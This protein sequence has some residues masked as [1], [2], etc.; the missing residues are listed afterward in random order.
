MTIALLRGELSKLETAER[1]QASNAVRQELLLASTVLARE[2][3]KTFIHLTVSNQDEFGDDIDQMRADAEEAL[4]QA[5]A[6]LQSGNGLLA[7]AGESHAQVV[8]K[9]GRLTALRARID[10]AIGVGDEGARLAAAAAWLSEA[11]A[12]IDD[13]QATRLDLLNDNRPTDAVLAAEANIRAY[14]DI[15]HEAVAFNEAIGVSLLTYEDGEPGETLVMVERILGR[16]SLAWQMIENEVDISLSS[17]VRAAIANAR[18]HYRREY[19]PLLL[20]LVSAKA[21]AATASMVANWEATSDKMLDALSALQDTVIV[22]SSERLELLVRDARRSAIIFSLVAGAG[23]VAAVLILL[24]VRRRVIQPI[25]RISGAMVR[26]A[27]NDLSTPVPRA[28]RLDE[29][30]VMT[31]ALRTF[32]ANAIQR[33]RTQREL[34]S[35]HQN[36]QRTFDQ[37]RHDLEAAATIQLAMLPAPAIVDGISHNGLYSPSSLVAGDT[38]NVIAQP[39]G[40]VGFFQIDVA[41]HGAAAALVSVA[42]QHTLSQAILTR[43]R[44]EP[45]EKILAQVNREWPEDLPYFTTILGEIDA[46]APVGR[47]VQAGHPSPLLIRSNGEVE[48][49]GGSGFPVGMVAQADYESIEFDFRTGDRLL[50]YSDGVVETENPRGAFYSEERLHDFVAGHAASATPDLLASLQNSLRKW[51]GESELTDDVSVLIVERTDL[52]S[53]HV[54]H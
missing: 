52:R 11:S 33:Q 27:D 37:L 30:G 43:R 7:R 54:I 31:N 50:I 51:R 2:R 36:L 20:Q 3:T 44:E 47:I 8:A 46:A 19:Y 24:V 34:Q 28:Q 6:A 16:V 48:P 1:L 45:I 4:E 26:L 41:G 32:K 12:L 42:G 38:Y 10:R 14:V 39:E 5:E 53:N 13:L 15:L 9:K 35:V 29:V 40:G 22:S 49:L 18:A 23:A 21:G 25:G 17:T